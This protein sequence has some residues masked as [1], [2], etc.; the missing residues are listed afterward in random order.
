MELREREDEGL[1]EA[2]LQDALAI[3]ALHQAVIAVLGAIT[4]G[5]QDA[6]LQPLLAAATAI[7]CEPQP[8]RWAAWAQ[9]PDR[10]DAAYPAIPT[11]AEAD[12]S[13][14]YETLRGRF[15]D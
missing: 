4:D 10:W 5:R 2:V 11:T 12:L 7:W 6:S 13:L 15:T 9:M 1:D 3:A 8:N 14:L